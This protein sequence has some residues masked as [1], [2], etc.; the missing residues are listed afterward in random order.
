MSIPRIYPPCEDDGAVA[1]VQ[2]F[3]S[4]F[5]TTDLSDVTECECVTG[6]SRLQARFGIKKINLKVLL[7]D[8]VL[9][10]LYMRLTD[11]SPLAQPT[12][13]VG[14]AAILDQHQARLA[15][16]VEVFWGC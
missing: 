9:H 11:S 2:I 15:V 6:C 10:V 13:S 7:D 8:A 16:G 5:W 3:V 1:V 14:G 12:S 4:I